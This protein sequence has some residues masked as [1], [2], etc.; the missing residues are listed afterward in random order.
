MAAALAA[1]TLSAAADGLTGIVALAALL[2]VAEAELLPLL[3]VPAFSSALVLA[4]A[5]AGLVP[6]LDT[7]G[8]DLLLLEA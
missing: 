6:G 3:T 7:A 5:V 1:F 2:L 4:E 8:L